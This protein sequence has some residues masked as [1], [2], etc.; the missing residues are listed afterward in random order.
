MTFPSGTP[1]TYLPIGSSSLI[2]LRSTSCS[3]AVTVKVL[4]SLPMRM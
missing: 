1:A 3:T 2:F 4:V